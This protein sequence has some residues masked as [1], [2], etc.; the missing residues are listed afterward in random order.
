MPEESGHGMHKYS[1]VLNASESKSNNERSTHCQCCVMSL[2]VS[3]QSFL[4]Y[5]PS[6]PDPDPV[7]SSARMCHLGRLELSKGSVSWLASC[8]YGYRP[9]AIF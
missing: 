7:P 2:T 6:S 9:L 3:A 4:P 8:V 5:P 1:R